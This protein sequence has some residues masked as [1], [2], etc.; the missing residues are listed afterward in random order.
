MTTNANI[1][2]EHETR[3]RLGVCLMRLGAMKPNDLARPAHS[4]VSFRSGLPYF[5]RSLGLFRKIGETNLRECLP[6][7]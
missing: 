5:E 4:K 1:I 6:G 2:A 3:E 7:T